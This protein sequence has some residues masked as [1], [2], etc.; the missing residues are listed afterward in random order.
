MIEWH[1]TDLSRDAELPH[2]RSGEVPLNLGRPKETGTFRPQRVCRHRGPRVASAPSALASACRSRG[3][4]G[5]VT[6]KT[7]MSGTPL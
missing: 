7:P 5:M 3:G 6:S 4:T 1:L 2:L